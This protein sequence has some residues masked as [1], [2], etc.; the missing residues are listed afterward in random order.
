MLHVST[1]TCSF[2]LNREQISFGYG[3]QVVFKNMNINADME[4]RIALVGENGTGKTT[5]VKLLTGELSPREGYRQAHRS[6]KTAF[7]SQHHVDQLVMD[8]TPLEFMQQKFPGK[9]E[10]EY[11]HAL[12][13]FGVSSDL[14]LRPIASLSGGQKSRLA[15]A[16][17]AVPRPNFLI[18]DEPTNHLDMESVE[19]LGKALNRFPGGVLLVSHDEHL[20]NLCCNAVWLCKDKLVHRLEGGLDQYKKAIQSELVHS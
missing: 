14:A 6:L 18:F 11:R 17:M 20:I 10:E 7:F 16:I 9:R 1:N 3:K 15:F 4:S 8:V 19:A 13:M 12:G 2:L 5:L